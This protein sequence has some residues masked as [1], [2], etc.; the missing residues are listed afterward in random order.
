MIIKSVLKNYK[1]TTPSLRATVTLSRVNGSGVSSKNKPFKK[2]TVGLKASAGRNNTGRITV[3][4]RCAGHKTKYRIISFLRSIFDIPAKVISIEYDPNRTCNIALVHYENGQYEY[5]IAQDGLKVGD[6]IM[7]S[8]DITNVSLSPGVSLPLSQMPI[9]THVSCIELKPHSGAKMARSAGAYAQVSGKDSGNVILKLPSGET[10]I[11]SG[12]C[13]ATI[14]VVSNLQHQNTKIGK[15]GRKRWLGFRSTVRGEA[16][17]P[18]DHPLGGRTRGGRH[19][20]SPWGQ[21]AKGLKTRRNKRTSMFII[22]RKKK[23]K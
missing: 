17:N 19:P 5:I 14:G 9:G 18:V 23:S 13:F 4:H 10:R 20:V 2:L 12:D 22:S 15:A 3:R 8:Y 1:P 21:A 7:S 6:T 11:V 16:M